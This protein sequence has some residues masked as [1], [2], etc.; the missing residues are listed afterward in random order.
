MKTLSLRKDIKREYFVVSF[1][2]DPKIVDAVRQIP[3]R[4]F[5]ASTKYWLI[6]ADHTVV[7]Y[8]EV[9]SK[10]FEFEVTQEVLDRMEQLKIPPSTDI[11]IPSLKMTLR[12]FQRLGVS[13]AKRSER[14]FIADDMGLGKTCES[15]AT[16]ESL[17]AYPCL[18]ACPASVKL[19][20]Q[21]EISM[22]TDRLSTIV[23]GEKSENCLYDGD[24]VI[25][26]YDILSHHQKQLESVGFKSIILDESHYV[27]GHKSQRT[28]VVKSIAKKIR[29]RFA[30]TGTPVLNKPRELI[31]Q[32]DILDRLN[33]LGGFWTFAKRYC[34]AKESNFGWDFSGHSNLDELHK[35]LSDTCFIRR[36]KSDVLEELPAKQ[37]T[38][39]P[40]EID[41][42]AEYKEVKKDFIKWVKK[43]LLN[44]KD[45]IEEVTQ[46]VEASTHL[47]KKQ[48]KFLIDAKINLKLSKAKAAEAV[49]KIEYLKQICARGKVK[50]FEEFIDNVLEQGNKLVVFAVHKEI[51]NALYEHYKDQNIARIFS[52]DDTPKR[53]ENIDKFQNDPECKLMVASL[54]AGGIGITLTAAS[55]VAFMEFGWNPAVHDQA[56][57][58][59]HRIGQKDSV[60]CYYFYG[61]DTID[62]DILELIENKRKVTQ[63]VTDGKSMD[64]EKSDIEKILRKF[65]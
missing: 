32:L 23:S 21:K 53:Q 39:V 38:F 10:Y 28:K 12:N 6:P 2:Y 49:I 58:R 25:I 55:T 17:K 8:V 22:W 57:D 42:P 18:V 24:F 46:E 56:E 63:A 62:E 20:W 60:N 11:E 14:C 3:Q 65:I 61:E 59:C 52:E 27:K 40:I 54:G 50:K 35:K 36:M 26:N 1:P 47:T 15:I 30:L 29:Y 44:R 43:R 45:F 13:Y 16:V 7:N 33:S 19:N 5:E 37:R 31:A 51:Q 41:N 9:F 4:K 48:K 34:D 64:A